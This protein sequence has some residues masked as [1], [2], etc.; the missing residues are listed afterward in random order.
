[1]NLRNAL[2]L[3]L[4]VVSTGCGYKL[5]FGEIPAVYR[6]VEV[7]FVEGDQTGMFTAE[8]IRAISHSGALTFVKC[9]GRTRLIVRILEFRDQNIG[10][11]YDRGEDNEIEK[12]LVPA[13]TRRIAIAEVRL[14][15]RLTGEQISG[16]DVIRASTEFDHEFNSSRDAVNV[17]SLGQVSDFDEAELAAMASLN[18]AL[19]R[20]IVDYLI[21]AW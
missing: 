8:L 9:G 12:T 4:L 17:F 3:F 2:L 21:H 10:F 1:M 18:R 19:A 15:D 7:P 16:P 14:V 11:R 20:K 13:E 5:G 6:T